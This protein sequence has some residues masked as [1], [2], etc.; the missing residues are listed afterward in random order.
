MS[1]EAGV[2]IDPW[3]H[4][5]TRSNC[6]HQEL[7]GRVSWIGIVRNGVGE[8]GLFLPTQLDVTVFSHADRWQLSK[9]EKSTLSKWCTHIRQWIRNGLRLPLPLNIPE[10]LGCF[11]HLERPRLISVINIPSRA[12]EI[13]KNGTG[14][15]P[16]N[17]ASKLIFICWMA[18]SGLISIST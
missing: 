6:F 9:H 16:S 14:G 2:Q 10:F 4:I 13:A 8:P 3:E 5:G 15:F 7:L 11:W 1:W 17:A 12:H 18:A